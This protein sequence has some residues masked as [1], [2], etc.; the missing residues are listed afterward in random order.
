MEQR[1]GGRRCAGRVMARHSRSSCLRFLRAAACCRARTRSRARPRTDHWRACEHSTFISLQT[2]STA[3]STSAAAFGWSP[4]CAEEMSMCVSCSLSALSQRSHNVTPQVFIQKAR[5]G[6]CG[7]FVFSPRK[8]RANRVSPSAFRQRQ[9]KS[10]VGVGGSH[11]SAS[12]NHIGLFR[13]V[14]H[15]VNRSQIGSVIRP[16]VTW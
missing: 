15:P 1:E 6:K 10:Q 12:Q 11:S 7:P 8:T 13:Q 4:V 3:L 16:I 14:E 5:R 2:R 9:C